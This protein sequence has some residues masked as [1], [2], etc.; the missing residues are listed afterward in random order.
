MSH[1][2]HGCLDSIS[3]FTLNDSVNDDKRFFTCST[4]CTKA[5][6]ALGDSLLGLLFRHDSTISS[7]KWPKIY[8]TGR[9]TCVA[10]EMQLTVKI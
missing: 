10:P 7:F 6:L 9:F 8:R 3:A 5:S 2:N 4:L 1:E